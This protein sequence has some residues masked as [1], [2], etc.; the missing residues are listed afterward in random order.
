MLGFL[1]FGALA[2][3]Y[4]LSRKAAGKPWN[5]EMDNNYKPSVTFLIPTHNESDV[6]QFKLENLRRL[7]YPRDLV[8]VIVVDSNSSDG[9]VGIVSN[10]ALEHPELNIELLVET[11]R[12]G[13]SAALNS[14][15]SHVKGDL[16]VVSDVDCFCPSYILQKTV[17][18]L[19][20]PR[21]GAV[22]GPK[23]L[24]NAQDSRVAEHESKYLES[25]NLTKLGESKMGFTPL[26]EGGFSAYRRTALVSFDPYKTGSD[27]C[28]TVIKLAEESYNALLVPEAA[29]FTTF[30]TTRSERYRIK[31]R[32]ANQLIRVFSKYLQLLLNG[33]ITS[34]RRTLSMNTFIYL[35]S[36]VFFIIFIGFTLP[37]FIAY[38]FMVFLLLLL[39]V[40][41]VGSIVIEAFQSFFVLFL[42]ILSVFSK[43][44]FLMW[45]K[46][47]D[48]QIFTEKM[49]KDHDLI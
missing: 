14:A 9:T 29:F 46:P 21:V 48:R 24:L 37:V 19:S 20:D 41:K 28:G 12:A 30:P 33:K 38:P 26:F 10:F 5:L 4:L 3:S 13:K 7:D 6:M 39:L 31:L 25:A 45:K 16:I 2:L 17:P 49:L 35:F 18:Y 11:E 23:L 42:G 22:S 43:K 1:S 27:D 32:R 8:Q 15:L 34:A 36:P 40:P 44:N 47:N